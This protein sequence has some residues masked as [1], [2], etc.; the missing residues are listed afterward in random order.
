MTSVHRSAVEVHGRSLLLKCMCPIS[1]PKKL[2]EDQL[3]E[4][5]KSYLAI[6]SLKSYGSSVCTPVEGRDLREEVPIHQVDLNRRDG[7]VI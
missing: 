6:H 4:I 7:V 2:S 5:I 3:S 1:F